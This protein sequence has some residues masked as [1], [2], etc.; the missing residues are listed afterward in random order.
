MDFDTVKSSSGY[1]A[2]DHL[3]CNQPKLLNIDISI[4][5]LASNM[6]ALL[7]L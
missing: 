7:I 1:V 6:S 2:N 4:S 5:H 3:Q